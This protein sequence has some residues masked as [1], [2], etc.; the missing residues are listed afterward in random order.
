MSVQVIF[1]FNDVIK[2]NKKA[3]VKNHDSGNLILTINSRRYF[4]YGN[5]ST[6]CCVD[7]KNINQ[8]LPEY[9]RNNNIDYSYG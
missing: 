2:V 5:D 6:H 7:C 9:L 1:N 8:E 3:T 4:S